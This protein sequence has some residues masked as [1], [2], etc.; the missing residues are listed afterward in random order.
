M[1]ST[2]TVMTSFQAVSLGHS[3][4]CQ[5][6]KLWLISILS[7]TSAW[8]MI[9]GNPPQRSEW[10][11]RTANFAK[12]FLRHVQ[13]MFAHSLCEAKLYHISSAT[14]TTTVAATSRNNTR[15]QMHYE[16]AMMAVGD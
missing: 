7:T 4:D 12:I 11:S 8:R 3:P 15:E 1:R 13:E 10:F 5:V 2:Q 9:S 6:S 16:K 14:L